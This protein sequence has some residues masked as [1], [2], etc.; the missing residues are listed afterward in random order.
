[1]RVV[2]VLRAPKP[3]VEA[4]PSLLLLVTRRERFF[5]QNGAPLRIL[6]IK[7]AAIV[8]LRAEYQR[9][10]ASAALLSAVILH[11]AKSSF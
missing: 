4:G 9:R 10:G 8:R 7:H 6:R 2:A 5:S 3:A 1:V 11:R